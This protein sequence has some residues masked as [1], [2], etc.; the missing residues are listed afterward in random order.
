VEELRSPTYEVLDVRQTER[1]EPPPPPFTTSLLQQQAFSRLRFPAKR[2]MRVAQQLYEGIDVGGRGSVGL[3][4]YMRSDSFR[5]APEALFEV[6]DLI[7][8]DFGAR[9]LPEKPIFRAARKGAQEAHEA[10]R[11]T[12]V[13]R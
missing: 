2:T 9:Y 11:P 1:A 6:R 12:D 4:T 8:K 7:A 3:I 13:A 5:V 10:I